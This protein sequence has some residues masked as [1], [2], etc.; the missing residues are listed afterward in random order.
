MTLQ[1]APFW[2][3]Q[4]QILSSDD[5]FWAHPS[6]KFIAMLKARR[7]MTEVKTCNSFEPTVKFL[8]LGSKS[9]F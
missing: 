3:S 2:S 6:V 4:V 7:D 9:V 1:V 5:E 8:S